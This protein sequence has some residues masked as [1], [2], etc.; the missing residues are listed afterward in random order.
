MVGAGPALSALL[1][2]I[3]LELR[4]AYIATTS[5]TP[6]A[7][8]IFACSLT[9]TQVKNCQLH[10]VCTKQAKNL[11][12]VH[13]M[14]SQKPQKCQTGGDV[15]CYS[16]CASKCSNTHTHARTGL[17]VYRQCVKFNCMQ[18]LAGGEGEGLKQCLTLSMGACLCKSCSNMACL[19]LAVIKG[20]LCAVLYRAS[21]YD[22]L[23]SFVLWVR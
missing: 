12:L 17:Y 1:L 20:S 5:C 19:M 4:N 8:T 13:V 11:L 16:K 18:L 7:K 6:V 9:R 14:C 2:A 3:A 10:W 22:R 21:T 15:Q 23:D